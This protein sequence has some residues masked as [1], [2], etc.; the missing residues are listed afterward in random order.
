MVLRTTALGHYALWHYGPPASKKYQRKIKEE[1]KKYQRTI[2]EESKKNQGRIKE[3]L[4]K[5]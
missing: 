2:K 4:K 3:E 5:N 1:S